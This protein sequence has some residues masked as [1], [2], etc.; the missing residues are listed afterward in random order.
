MS[1]TSLE[2]DAALTEKGLRWFDLEEL[3]YG[4]ESLTLE[5]LGEVYGIDRFGGEGQGDR[6][7]VVVKLVEAD[8][9]ETYYRRNGWYQSFNGAELDGPTEIVKPSEKIV[10]IWKT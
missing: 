3:F 6:Y 2:F 1:I 8:G 5:P 7:W 10:R 9:T 4:D